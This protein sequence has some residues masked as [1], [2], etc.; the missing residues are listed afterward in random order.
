[1]LARDLSSPP[2]PFLLTLPKTGT[3]GC[4]RDSACGTWTVEM[5]AAH[6]KSSAQKELGDNQPLPTEIDVTNRDRS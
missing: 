6:L 5:L 3:E 4:E 2:K 1:M